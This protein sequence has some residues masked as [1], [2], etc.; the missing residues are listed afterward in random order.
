MENGTS[1]VGKTASKLNIFSACL[2]IYNFIIILRSKTMIVLLTINTKF[3]YNH[4]KIP[5][6]NYIFKDGF[7]NDDNNNNLVVYRDGLV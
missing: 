7:C 2:L 5:K 1:Y 3:C 4:I 6:L